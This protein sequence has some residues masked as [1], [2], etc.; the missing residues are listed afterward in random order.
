V[1]HLRELRDGVSRPVP[2]LEDLSR[3]GIARRIQ[4]GADA[5]TRSSTY[6]KSRVWRP[7]AERS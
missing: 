5:A 7:V 2:D 1:H 6:T 4:G 3:G